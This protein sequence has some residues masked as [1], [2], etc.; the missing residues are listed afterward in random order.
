MHLVRVNPWLCFR[1][2][3]RPPPTTHTPSGPPPSSTIPSSFYPPQPVSSPESSPFGSFPWD[4]RSLHPYVRV[5]TPSWKCPH[6]AVL[7]SISK[8]VLPVFNRTSSSAVAS[9]TLGFSTIIS[10][11]KWHKTHEK[12]STPTQESIWKRRWRCPLELQ[13]GH[14]C[15][16]DIWK[17][18]PL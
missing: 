7:R 3:S 18:W 11:Q 13:Q 15:F 10:L 6:C 12:T 8:M 5:D 9:D 16:P 17:G 2:L 14:F 1:K 4:L